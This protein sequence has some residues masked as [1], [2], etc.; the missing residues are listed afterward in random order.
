MM[1]NESQMLQSIVKPDTIMNQD[2]MTID[3]LNLDELSSLK[4]FSTFSVPKKTPRKIL[5]NPSP[6]NA[7][8]TDNTASAFISKSNS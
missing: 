7:Y 1:T 2:P 5:K 8:F 3:E 6:S 4:S